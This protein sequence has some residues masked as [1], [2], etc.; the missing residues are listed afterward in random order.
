MDTSTAQILVFGVLALVIFGFASY[1]ADR[2]APST[3]E[4][5]IAKEPPTLL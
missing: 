4:K 3:K 2:E 1:M 5:N